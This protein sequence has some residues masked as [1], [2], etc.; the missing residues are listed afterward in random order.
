MRPDMRILGLLV[1]ILNINMVAL[2]FIPVTHILENIK[3]YTLGFTRKIRDT[4]NTQFCLAIYLQVADY[5][6]T[7]ALNQHS[8]RRSPLKKKT[9]KM[10]CPVAVSQTSEKN[11]RKKL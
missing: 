11:I 2:Y 10:H 6:V 7:V 1:R 4:L 8:E 5:L 3:K 9:A